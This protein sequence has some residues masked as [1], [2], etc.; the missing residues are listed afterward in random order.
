MK[1]IWLFMRPSRMKVILVL[2][3]TISSLIVTTGFE[4][5]SKLSWHAN[6]GFPYPFMTISDYFPGRWCPFKAICIASNIR[7]FYPDRMIL[8]ILVWYVV[9]CAI[10]SVYQ[11]VKK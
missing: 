5:T 6:R 3:L 1:E 2:L 11:R 4:A 7:D 10:T 8:N 9:S